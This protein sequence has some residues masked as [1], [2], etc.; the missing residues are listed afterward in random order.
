MVTDVPS[1]KEV[2]ASMAPLQALGKAATVVVGDNT[3]AESGF[4]ASAK[5][6]VVSLVPDV[7]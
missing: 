2:H 3:G 1:A 5:L 7:N 6:H 4:P